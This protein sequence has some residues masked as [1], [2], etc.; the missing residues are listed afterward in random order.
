MISL[1]VM[2]GRQ[3]GDWFAVCCGYRG[4]GRH[5]GTRRGE[6]GCRDGGMEDAPGKEEDR[7][8]GESG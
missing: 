1:T 4:S 3:V 6:E 7:G 8:R 2:E 5:L